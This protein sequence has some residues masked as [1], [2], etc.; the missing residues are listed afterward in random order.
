MRELHRDPVVEIHP[1]TAAKEGLQEGDWVIIE[2]ATGESKATRKENSLQALIP[3]SP[4][5]TRR[6]HGWWFPERTDPGHGWDESNINVLTDNAYESC[7]P[8][9]GATPVRTLLCKICP[10]KNKGD[11]IREES[12]TPHRRVRLLGM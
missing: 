12:G 8:A 2:S 7:D 4:G 1:E 11:S 10:E 6:R 5:S 3:G 9:M